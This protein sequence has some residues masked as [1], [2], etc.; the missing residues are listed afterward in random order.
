MTFAVDPDRYE[1]F[2]GRYARLLAPRVADAVA[3]APG[4]RALDVGCGSGALLDVLVE[5]CGV[6]NVCAIDPSRPFVEHCRRRH[7]RADVRQGEAEALPWRDGQFDIVVAQLVLNFLRDR[8]AGV[9]EMARVAAPGG[10]VAAATWAI[11]RGMEMLDAFWEAARSLDPNV[12]GRNPQT[13]VG[14]AE[15]RS[16]FEGA[17]LAAVELREVEVSA[18]YSDFAELWDSFAVGVGPPGS[19]LR[20]L[21]ADA[22]RALAHELWCLLGK[23]SGAFTLTARAWLAIG[24]A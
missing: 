18:N 4:R 8:A 21:A 5:R 23:P 6:E 14:R 12:E 22:R 16:L 2:M 15:L 3:A 7:P 19:Y 9:A 17:G 24:R 1:R 20:G 13:H 11:D 10:R